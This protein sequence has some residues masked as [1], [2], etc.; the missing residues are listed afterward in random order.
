M[1]LLDVLDTL[2]KKKLSHINLV[3]RVLRKKIFW[4]VGS[5]AEPH[6][7]KMTVK[8][9]ISVSDFEMFLK[10]FLKLIQK[11]TDFSSFL[12]CLFFKSYVLIEKG[13]AG[14][15]FVGIQRGF[16]V[17]VIVG[18]GY[19]IYFWDRGRLTS[20]LPHPPLTCLFFYL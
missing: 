12:L 17:V 10:N 15:I 16:E 19:Y 2:K 3:L 6:Y 14:Q 13:H 7:Q 8:C 5:G 9:Q 20:M 18:N 11:L 4:K 1:L